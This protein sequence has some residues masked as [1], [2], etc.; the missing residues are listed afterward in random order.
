VGLMTTY[1]ALALR[2]ALSL[3]ATLVAF[4]VAAAFAVVARLAW[5]RAVGRYASA[6][7]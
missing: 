3:R 5:S 1:P 7:S 6:S 4:G 2:G